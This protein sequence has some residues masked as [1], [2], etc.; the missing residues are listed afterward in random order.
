MNPHN[1]SKTNIGLK[2][3]EQE[4]EICYFIIAFSFENL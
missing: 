2:V 1:F 3:S 4:K